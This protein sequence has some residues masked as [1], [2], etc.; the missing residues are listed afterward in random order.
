MCIEEYGEY[1]CG[2]KHNQAFRQCQAWYGQN[3]MCNPADIQGICV[4][5]SIHYCKKCMVRQNAPLTYQSDAQLAQQEQ[6][7]ADD[8]AAALDEMR[9]QWDAR[10]FRDWQNAVAQGQVADNQPGFFAWRH[11]YQQQFHRP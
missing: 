5:K 7:Q 2:H 6:R 4:Y 10:A 8:E 11:A 1:V 3:I 9:Q